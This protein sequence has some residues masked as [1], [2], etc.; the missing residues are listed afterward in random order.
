M[1]IDSFP[2]SP[3]LLFGKI[4]FFFL[5]IWIAYL[6][7]KANTWKHAL[8]LCSSFIAGMNLGVQF[9]P[10]ILGALGGGLGAGALA[11]HFL[12]MRQFP[13][14]ALSIG[15][16]ALIAIGRLGCLFA[17][18][19]F[20]KRSELP[21]AIHYEH[22]N[23]VWNFHHSLQWVTEQS[24]WSMGIHPYPLYESSGLLIGILLLVFLR[25]SLKG[26]SPLFFAISF[27]LALRALIDPFRAMINLPSALQPGLLGLSLLQWVL[28]T[29]SAGAAILTVKLNRTATASPLPSLNASQSWL[30]FGI[31]LSV[32]YWSD[33]AQTP[34]LHLL[35]CLC[36]LLLL[37]TLIPPVF[38]N[39]WIARPLATALAIPQFALALDTTLSATDS[40]HPQESRDWIYAINSDSALLVRIGNQR[41][42][43]DKIIK[44]ANKAGLKPQLWLGGGFSG[45]AGEYQVEDAC[46]GGYTTYN[47]A[48]FNY[49]FQ[50]EY[51]NPL[52]PNLNLWIGSRIGGHY[53][54]RRS[55]HFG[56]SSGTLH[57]QTE[58]PIH[59]TNHYGTLANWIELEHLNY[60]LGIGFNILTWNKT[61]SL[62]GK[63]PILPMAHARIGFSSFGSEAN[64]GGRIPGLDDPQISFGISGYL[65]DKGKLKSISQADAKY[66]LGIS[67][68]NGIRFGEPSSVAGLI[69]YQRLS[70]TGIN[71]Y[72][73]LGIG[74]LPFLGMGLSLPVLH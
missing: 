56:D 31:I 66:F 35:A 60:S 4:P 68:V 27:D 36:P 5:L 73:H 29:L 11:Y 69:Q 59:E 44:T 67:S 57:S 9:A 37:P 6:S 30:I 17:G 2:F 12:R 72:A 52:S 54:D 64:Y 19:C 32:N 24:P 16:L 49:H 46:G 63:N 3:W 20:G 41:D 47:D 21:W 51:L 7:A 8:I 74:H 70:Q 38:K 23:P 28:V 18:C 34:F 26:S 25:T 45:G 15:L 53:L 10:S 22:G 71:G 61:D 33:S 55:Q 43:L 13:F 1:H 40:I 39:A 65:R 50:G 58:A 48:N 14:W 62:V 42:S